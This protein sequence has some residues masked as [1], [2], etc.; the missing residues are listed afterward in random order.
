MIGESSSPIELMAALM[1]PWAHTEWD[2]LTF[3]TEMIWTWQPFSASFMAAESPARPPPTTITFF[4][5]FEAGI[6][7]RLVIEV[8]PIGQPDSRQAEKGDQDHQ[9]SGK[10][11]HDALRSIC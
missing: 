1:P 11:Q 8:Y 9:A 4:S 7:L 2:L 3:V 5:F 6:N 10:F